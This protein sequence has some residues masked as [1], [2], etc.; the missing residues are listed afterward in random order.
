[1][2]LMCH[3]H[4]LKH[5]IVFSQPL[6]KFVWGTKVNRTDLFKCYIFQKITRTNVEG[7]KTSEES[8]ILFLTQA[9]Q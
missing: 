9:Q 5:V 2:G 1:M 8:A 3:I 6:L 4:K 7:Y